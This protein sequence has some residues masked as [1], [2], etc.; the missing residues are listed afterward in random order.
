MN[1]DGAICYICSGKITTPIKFCDCAKLVHL[2]CLHRWITTSGNDKC[3]I[4]KSDYIDLNQYMK[5]KYMI[6]FCY[7]VITLI[8]ILMTI[9]L[10]SY[11]IYY[12]LNHIKNPH[13]KIYSVMAIIVCA[14]FVCYNIFTFF[15][16][17]YQE[18]I[19]IYLE[20]PSNSDSDTSSTSSSDVL[21]A[22]EIET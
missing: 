9:G 6:P 17:S 19:V 20:G 21:I 7:R 15:Q 22:V 16:R 12:A 3:E 14:I 18:E 2:E 11:L 13:T 10:T 4:C 5:T 1:N 8:S